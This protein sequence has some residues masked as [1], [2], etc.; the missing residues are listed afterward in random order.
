[1][2]KIL[3]TSFLVTLTKSVLNEKVEKK[4][5]LVW[6]EEETRVLSDIMHIKP[7]LLLKSVK[8]QLRCLLSET[9]LNSS[10]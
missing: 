3:G 2:I 5:Q 6:V 10:D 7:V 9:F 8:M 4:V 1:M